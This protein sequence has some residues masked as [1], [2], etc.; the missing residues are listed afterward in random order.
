MKKILS[1]RVFHWLLRITFTL[2]FIYIVNRNVLTK[3]G[4]ITRCFT[5][6]HMCT[7]V[8]F[9]FGG[10]YFQVKRWEIILRF[11]HF[12]LAQHVP[13]KTI[14]WGNLL[15]FITPGRIGELFRG[16]TITPDR[17]ADS[18]FAVIID[19]LFIIFT[20]LSV[21]LISI[22]SMKWLLKAT[23]TAEMTLFLITA[24]VICTIG[25][26][27]L[28]TG[29]VFDKKHI[30]TKILSR[31]LKNIPRLFNPA[32]R[33]ALF[34]SF[35]AHMCLICQTVTLLSM[36]GS[37]NM[38]INIVAVG[39]AYGVMPF[40][41]FT[42]GNMGVRE[43]AFSFF[44]TYLG[45]KVNAGSYAIESISLGTSIIILIMNIVL[46]AFIGLMWYL[47]DNPRSKII[48]S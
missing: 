39:L 43:G 34:F 31:I 33:K 36:F 26:I 40:F 27:I 19:K 37:G 48:K 6:Q 17:K 9:S 44:L 47:L 20:V 23:I 28:L 13:W 21:G 35:A 2:L 1:N 38:V 45:A 15:A 32:G 7:M 10:L 29:K 46:P 3:L 16:I 11:Q 41:S 18:L 24:F 8:V 14:L 42:I 4:C 22:L 5:W 12:H 30:V 25:L